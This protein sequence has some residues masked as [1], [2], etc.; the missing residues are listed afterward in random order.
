MPYFKVQLRRGCVETCD[1]F[2]EAPNMAAAE[3]FA[4]SEDVWEHADDWDYEGSPDETVVAVDALVAP[5]PFE[6]NVAVAVD[7]NGIEA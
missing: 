7:E 4:D 5:T 3:M 2:V 6:E 1:V